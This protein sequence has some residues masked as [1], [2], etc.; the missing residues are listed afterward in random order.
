MAVRIAGRQDPLGAASG[1]EYGRE[2]RQH[3]DQAPAELRENGAPL[4]KGK[5]GANQ[6]AVLPQGLKSLPERGVGDA[7]DDTELG[8]LEPLAQQEQRRAQAG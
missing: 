3:L 6:R 8:L 1:A 2:P 7:E 5:E 4:G